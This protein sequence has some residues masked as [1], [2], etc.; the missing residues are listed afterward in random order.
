MRGRP[1]R[2][3]SGKV[4]TLPSL[5]SG[6]EDSSCA[7]PGLVSYSPQG[8]TTQGSV[9]LSR[10]MGGTVMEKA[11]FEGQEIIFDF[12]TSSNDSVNYAW[13]VYKID[14]RHADRLSAELE[15]VNAWLPVNAGCRVCRR[16][17]RKA[18]ANEN[19]PGYMI[20]PFGSGFSSSNW[21]DFNGRVISSG[22]T[23][24][25]DGFSPWTAT[26][27]KT[28]GALKNSLMNAGW[29][30]VGDLG[31][32]NFPWT[33]Q[34]S[35]GIGPPANYPTFNGNP[36]WVVGSWYNGGNLGR[37]GAFENPDPVN[38]TIGE[39]GGKDGGTLRVV[40]SSGVTK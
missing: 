19:Y 6:K 13:H 3:V 25:I 14:M 21:T 32:S 38:I 31:D 17:A 2:K 18:G 26:R 20:G 35:K 34:G 15:G 36:K 28:D 24:W 22:Q 39:M 5:G 4:I 16:Q 33:A 12:K 29:C 9:N 23:Q 8:S 27:P 40:D 1:K 10:A 11:L 7:S 37:W 30:H